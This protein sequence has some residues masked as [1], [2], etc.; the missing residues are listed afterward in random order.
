MPGQKTVFLLKDWSLPICHSSQD[1]RAGLTPCEGRPVLWTPPSALL[2]SPHLF[3]ICLCTE[4][5]SWLRYGAH[6]E[7]S[8]IY[9]WTPG[10]FWWLSFQPRGSSLQLGAVFEWKDHFFFLSSREDIFSWL[11]EREKWREAGREGSKEKETSMW[12]RNMAGCLFIC[13]PTGDQTHSLGMCPD[14]ESNLRTF[15]LWGDTEAKWAI[16]ARAKGSFSEMR[17]KL[18]PGK[19]LSPIKLSGSAHPRILVFPDT[20]SPVLQAIWAE[21]TN[22][23]ES[24]HLPHITHIVM[25]RVKDDF[26]KE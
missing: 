8:C 21:K 16:V 25:N 5:P 13:T 18:V 24:N 1:V 2:P 3:R 14:W 10:R 6:C 23:R 7:Q 12:E 11:L 26:S 19:V 4:S 9:I 15:G 22:A 20:H 17:V